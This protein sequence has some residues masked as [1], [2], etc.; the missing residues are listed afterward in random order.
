VEELA[1]LLLDGATGSLR[2]D[3]PKSGVMGIDGRE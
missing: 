2:I 1:A 3:F